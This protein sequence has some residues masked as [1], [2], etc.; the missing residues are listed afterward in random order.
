MTEFNK[1]TA[2]ERNLGFISPEEQEKI[3]SSAIAVAGAGGDGGLLAIQLARMGFGEIRLADPDPFEIENLNRQAT[4]TTES[5]GINKAESVAEYLR[6]I[7]PEINVV[8][9]NEGINKENVDEFVDG[10]DLLIDETEY[11]VH[12]LGVMLARSARRNNIPN[13]MALNLGFGT[14]VTT[15]DPKG[16]SLEANL[17]LSESA[18]L[19]EI[20][21]AEVPIS[22]WLPYIPPY[23]D[24]SVL[25]KVAKGEKSAP[26]VAPGVALAAGMGAT[27]AFLNIV[28]SQNNRP[29]PVFAPRLLMVD[30]MTAEAKVL[31]DP[32]LSH[33][34]YMARVAMNNIFKRVPKVDY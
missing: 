16:R 28:H 4:C 29:K 3:Q 26:S 7:N 15:Y 24:L 27:Q 34:K 9:Y 20:E 30:A 10:A 25:E 32:V 19:E 33:Y 2:F 5:I 17:G 22:R 6:S 13:L 12:S 18:S 8:V 31:R 21:K 23:G 1:K 11:T 14:V